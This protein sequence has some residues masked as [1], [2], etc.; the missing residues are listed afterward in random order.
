MP[1]TEHVNPTVVNPTGPGVA[2]IVGKGPV[3]DNPV[4]NTGIAAA[5]VGGTQAGFAALTG[6]PEVLGTSIFL[7]L[8]AQIVKKPKW[9]P[10]H[11]GLIVI[12]FVVAFVVGIFLLFGVENVGKAF[13]N[14][15]NATMQAILNYKGDKAGGLNVMPPLAD[16][17]S[18]TR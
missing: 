6:G 9:F 11:E 2:P 17:Q 16:E 1:Q 18:F 8:V 10:E 14:A 13:L 12:M 4:V 15:A 5:V 3:T 7:N